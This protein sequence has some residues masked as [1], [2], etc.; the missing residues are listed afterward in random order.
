M[1]GETIMKK[2]YFLFL[3]SLIMLSCDCRKT[4]IVIDKHVI[5]H[6]ITN[7]HYYLVVVDSFG[8]KDIIQTTESKYVLYSIGDTI[9]VIR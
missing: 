5:H 4:H 8:N 1:K 6:G 9:K 3:L 2:V 7:D